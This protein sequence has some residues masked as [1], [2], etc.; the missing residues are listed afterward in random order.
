MRQRVHHPLDGRRRCGSS[1]APSATPSTRAS[2]SWSTPVAGSIATSAASPSRP[3]RRP[4]RRSARLRHRRSPATRRRSA[5]GEAAVSNLQTHWS[6]TELLAT[7]DRRRAARSCDGVRCHG[8]FD[9]N[10]EYV[11]PRTKFRVPATERVAAGAPRGVRHRHH[12]RAARHVADVV[13]RRRAGEVPR[14]PKAC[15]VRSSRRSRASAPSKVS[16]R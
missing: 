13:P 3:P 11:S 9:A 15:A 8:G 14:S 6:E 2:R 10:G 7:D 12:R 4:P 1:S 16:A 5:P